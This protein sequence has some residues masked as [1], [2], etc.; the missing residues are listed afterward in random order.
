MKFALR[1]SGAGHSSVVELDGVDVSA[2]VYAVDLHVEASNEPTRVVLT[3]GPL[4]TDVAAEAE[5]HL[6]ESSFA[7]LKQLGWTPPAEEK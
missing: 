4:S 7:L 6:T 3:L 1:T 2:G 5:V